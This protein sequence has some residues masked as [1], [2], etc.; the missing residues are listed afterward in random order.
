MVRAGAG[1]GKTTELT[2][3]VLN[4]TEMYIAHH[5][6]FPRLVVTTFTRKATQELRERLWL[7]A[8]RRKNPKLEE[9]LRKTHLLHISTIHG[10][11]GL[12]L[13]EYGSAMGLMPGFSYISDEKN[14]QIAKKILRQMYSE[15]LSEILLEWQEKVSLET[16][17]KTILEF[18][19][20]YEFK[21]DIRTIDESYF[22]V[23]FKNMYRNLQN[24]TLHLA[25]EIFS[26]AS[27]E[28]WIVFAN[29]LDQ[30]EKL[31]FPNDPRDIEVI[32]QWLEGWPPAKNL[33]K[34]LPESII[35]EKKELAEDW[36]QLIT[37]L[38]NTDWIEAIILN[39]QKFLQLADLFLNQF[40]R[41][42]I[43]V[44]QITMGDLESLTL[45]LIKDF[46]STADAF[47]KDWDYWLIDEYQDTSPKQVHILKKLIG[48]RKKFIVGDPQQS[49]YLFRGARSNVFYEA[50]EEMQ[51][52][53]QSEFL[54]LN[55]NYRSQPRLLHFFNWFF[56]KLGSQFQPMIP[57]RLQTDFHLLSSNEAMVYYINE[58]TE[59][60]SDFNELEKHSEALV[61]LTHIQRLVQNGASLESICVLS[62]RNKD[63][64]KF[65]TQANR[66]SYP[67]QVHSSGQFYQKMEVKDAL[68]M[69]R[70]LVNPHDNLNL[71]KL[72]RSPWFY[73]SDSDLVLLINSQFKSYWL[74]LVNYVKNFDGNVSKVADSTRSVLKSLMD[75]FEQQ[76]TDGVI[77]IWEKM[78]QQSG[79]LQTADQFDVSGRRL[80]NLL[81]LMQTIRVQERQVGFQVIDFLNEKNKPLSPDSDTEAEASPVVLPSRINVMT[82]HASKGLQFD[83]VIILGCGNYRVTPEKDFMDWEEDEGILSC[84]E[85]DEDNQKMSRHL[86]MRQWSESR[87]K[88]ELEEYDRVLYVAMTRA[89]KDLALIAEKPA[90][91]SW[92]GRW[93]VQMSQ[94]TDPTDDSNVLFRYE[95]NPVTPM[96]PLPFQN[97]SNALQA[98][99]VS[100]KVTSVSEYKVNAVGPRSLTTIST[101]A[102]VEQ[103]FAS[104]E[105]QSTFKN[106]NT[107]NVSSVNWMYEALKKARLGTDIHKKFEEQQYIHRFTSVH[108][109]INSPETQ[110]ESSVQTALDFAMQWQQGLLKQIMENGFAEKSFAIQYRSHLIQGQIDLW[111]RSQSNQVWIVDY[112]TGDSKH[113]EKAFLQLQIYAW[114]LRAL[115][116]VESQEVIQLLALYPLT[117]EVYVELAW[118]QEK[119]QELFKWA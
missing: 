79:I 25:K 22:S 62:R 83:H 65:V 19:D 91:L 73:V 58:E 45:K 34:E 77:T 16:I 80:A 52:D 74:S 110:P 7:E 114:A 21:S 10:V 61:A 5:E 13:N 69:L 8:I 11:L 105:S 116:R 9:Y 98:S 55:T 30:I 63:L 97:I 54:L 75:Y 38:A 71:L 14:Y 95:I 43:K 26:L 39:S 57:G 18:A 29:H 32:Q 50:E 66:F 17:L 51:K 31:S 93:P 27:R 81:K 101:T 64:E 92:A 106:A 59:K 78:L 42:K 20:F 111:G 85:Y 41:Y 113:K 118:P 2:Q 103:Y 67:V 53:Q 96:E 3:R 15:N 86:I 109:Q 89:K 23:F 115:H 40:W 56:S 84:A 94:S 102:I 90:A 72:L 119:I 100:S 104:N 76:K 24:R 49:I 6:R 4:I 112:K 35:K 107:K 82:I 108:S 47:S 1:A 70:F 87:Q 99:S 37:K 48:D 117:Q 60:K 12:F 36:E 46:P 88:Q 68:S 33:K 44:G 28:A